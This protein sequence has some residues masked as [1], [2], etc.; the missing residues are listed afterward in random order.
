[1]IDVM[2]TIKDVIGDEI[3]SINDMTHEQIE[4][5]AGSLT[6][7]LVN[8]G[9]FPYVNDEMNEIYTQAIRL[10]LEVALSGTRK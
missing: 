1:M 2:T 5:M 8:G 6:Q 9:V 3:E 7:K 10:V 4:E